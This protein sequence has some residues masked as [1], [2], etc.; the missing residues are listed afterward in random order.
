MCAELVVQAGMGAA[1]HAEKLQ[2]CLPFG[3]GYMRVG[4]CLQ[5][6]FCHGRIICVDRFPE[7]CQAAAGFCVRAGSIMQQEPD[8]LRVATAC[9]QM[10]RGSVAVRDIGIRPRFQ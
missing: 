8:K 7:G 4:T 3:V 10:Q 9:R 1:L 2:R 5:K 6:Y